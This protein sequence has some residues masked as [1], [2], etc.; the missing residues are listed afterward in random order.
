MHNLRDLFFKAS[1]P[2]RTF[3]LAL[4]P[5]SFLHLY[6]DSLLWYQLPS[7]NIWRVRS[8]CCQL[9][10]LTSFGGPRKTHLWS[11]TAFNVRII[12]K[13]KQRNSFT[14]A[15]LTAGGSHKEDPS[16]GPGALGLSMK[17]ELNSDP[18]SVLPQLCGSFNKPL[19]STYKK[20]Q[21]TIWNTLP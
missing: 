12:P 2:G 14:T 17:A 4:I 1:P 10:L 15:P 13:R 7:Y 18:N 20:N 8:P 6:D 21:S 9:P 19:I 11:P 16:Q 5:N 3:G